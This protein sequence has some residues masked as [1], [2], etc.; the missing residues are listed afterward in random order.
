L[1]DR[2][3]APQRLEAVAEALFLSALAAAPW[4]Y[5]ST[6]DVYRFGQSA[7]LLLGTALWMLAALQEGRGVPRLAARAAALPALGLVQLVFATSAAPVWTGEALLV[8]AGALGAFAFWS[9]RGREK[10]AAYRLALVVAA[11]AAAQ[12]VFGAVQWSLAPDRIYGGATP[13]VTSPF[14]SFVNHNHFAGFVA[15]AT[16]VV[17]G[18]AVGTARRAGG[19]DAGTIGLAGL[20]L[21]LATVLVASRSRGGLVALAAGLVGLGV[22]S[23]AVGTPGAKPARTALTA[24][25]TAAVL[26][27]TFGV[28]AV[29][30]ATREHLLTLVHGP[31]DTSGE[32]RVDMAAATLRLAAAHPLLGSGLGAYA[33]AI[34][35][36]KLRHGEVRTTHAESDVL[37]F[38][39]EAGLA[40]LLLVV[41]LGAAIVSSLANRLLRGHDP[42]RK[43]LALGAGAAGLALLV[44]SLVD[45]NLRIPSNALLGACVLGLAAAPR[46]EPAAG[47][48]RWTSGLAVLVLLLASA[49]ATWRAVGAARLDAARAE[50]DFQFRIARLDG[51]LARHPFLAEGFA[52]RGLAWQALAAGGARAAPA[53]LARAARDFE[54]ALTLR[55]RW[56][57]AWAELGWVRALEGNPAPALAALDTAVALDPTDFRLSAMRAEVLGR[58]GRAPDATLELLRVRGR[59]ALWTPARAQQIAR[60]WTSDP[61]LLARLE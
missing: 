49:G 2:G 36:L 43:G 58:Q 47:G 14:G 51:T 24:G 45:F 15:M 59:S 18:F 16:L 28:V 22:A 10:P 5:G 29:P 40:G 60:G 3:A 23:W 54:R 20:T 1:T 35:P 25:A 4:P 27:L 17:A 32:Y 11:T 52:E 44:H 37:E 46:S 6:A 30:Q 61:A 19:I 55:P 34:P 9:E 41:W 48:R 39:A 31:V 42:R 21:G 38:L 26:V 53:R 57:S 33:D 56:A 50:S 7:V 8:L 12:A 13:V